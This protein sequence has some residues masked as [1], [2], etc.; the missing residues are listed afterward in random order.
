MN[1]MTEADSIDTASTDVDKGPNGWEVFPTSGE[2]LKQWRC[3]LVPIIARRK[4][5]C[6]VYAYTPVSVVVVYSGATGAIRNRWVMSGEIASTPT[7]NAQGSNVSFE[8][9]KGRIYFLTGDAR[10]Y[11]EGKGQEV[12]SVLEVV[13]KPPMSA[14][15]F[16]N[17]SFR[18]H[19]YD[20]GREE[21]FFSDASGRYRLLLK[22]V[23]G[24]DGH[25]D[26]NASMRLTRLEE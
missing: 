24:S 3:E 23:L 15:G 11:D 22:A 21:L 12:V 13:A 5:L 6:T 20:P 16:S 4:T 9:R 7:L 17:D 10:L 26:R 18:F 8:G 14:F 19:E 2:K 25:I 1:F